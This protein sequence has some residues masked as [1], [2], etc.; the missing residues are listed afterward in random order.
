MFTKGEWKILNEGELGTGKGFRVLPEVREDGT[1]AFSC[2][3]IGEYAFDNANLIVALPDMYEALKAWG[4]LRA[5]HPLDSGADID[6]IFR[7]CCDIT[8][9]ALAKAEGK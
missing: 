4:K 9:K 1:F 8:D 2:E 5:M 6:A 7:E 3:I